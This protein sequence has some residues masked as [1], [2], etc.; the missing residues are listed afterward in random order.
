MRLIHATLVEVETRRADGVARPRAGSP[1]PLRF[2]ISALS[3]RCS[4]APSGTRRRT[5]SLFRSIARP[6]VFFKRGRGLLNLTPK[7][8]PFVRKILELRN[9]WNLFS[10]CPVA[11]RFRGDYRRG[12]KFYPPAKVGFFEKSSACVDLIQARFAARQSIKFT[13]YPYSLYSVGLSRRMS[14]PTASCY[15]CSVLLLR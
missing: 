12:R 14:I 10:L 6:G 9:F 8:C 5:P 15:G 3:R 7:V 1:R 4:A 11:S 13:P 2:T